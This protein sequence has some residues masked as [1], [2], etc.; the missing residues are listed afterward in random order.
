M[1][2]EEFVNNY[3]DISIVRVYEVPTWKKITISC[4]WRGVTA[5]SCQN[6]KNTYRNNPQFKLKVPRFTKAMI[7]MQQRDKRGRGGDETFPIGWAIHS[8]SGK[9]VSG[10]PSRSDYKSGSHNKKET[11]Q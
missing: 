10:Y 8:N 3:S 4:G 1:S 9:K 7:S 5:G 6:H 2:L 11:F